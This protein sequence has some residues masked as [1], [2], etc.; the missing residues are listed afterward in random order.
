M[1]LSDTSIDRP[2]LT[3]VVTASILLA[4]WLG[5]QNL[6]VRELPDVEYPI[7]NVQTVL[8]G[9][10]PEVMETEVTEVLEEE[11]NTIEGIKTLSSV[12]SEQTSTITAEFELSRDVD[13]A[14]QDVRARVSRVSQQ[15]PDDVEDP[16]IQ[17][18]DP[19][20]QP[21]MW[22]TVRNPNAS[23]TEMNDIAENV[24]QERLQTIEG[25]G[26]IQVGG[27]RRF[28]VRIDLDPQQMG[29]YGLT[30]ADVSAALQSGNV[31]VPSGRIESES[32]EFTVRTEGE[33]ETPE[34]FNE[35][36]VGYRRGTPIRLSDVG[37][38]YGG[39]EN[40]RSLAR[41]NGDPTVG[42]GVVKQSGANTVALA[43]RALEAVDELRGEVPAGYDLTVAVNSAE[44]IEQSLH[45]VEETLFIAF[46]LVVLV[47][48]LFLQSGRAT[49]IPSLAIPVSIVGTFAALY[50]L[51][52]SVNTL[53]LL[54]LVLAI[55]IVVDD[56]IVVVENIHRHLEEGE[57]PIEAARKGTSEIAFAVIAISLTLVIVFLPIGLMQGI[58]GRLFR[59]FGI[60]V[61]VSVLI[62]AFVAL[63][64]S[65]MLSSRFL[66]EEDEEGK[67]RV[68]RA[69]EAVLQEGTDWYRA[70]LEWSLD[71]RWL[72]VGL[73]VVSLAATAFVA[74][75]MGQE[76]VPR[77]DRGQIIVQMQAPVGS[78]LEYTDSYLQQ[79]EGILGE[80]EGV[81]RYFSAAGF[82]GDVTSGFAYVRLE[83]E[84]ERGQFEIMDEIRGRVGQLAGVDVFLI[85]P[86]SLQQGAGQPVQF[87]VQ[88][89]DLDSLSHYAD[90]LA[91]RT[92]AL[93]GF[94]GVDTNVDLNKPELTV[95]V[96]RDKA[97]SLGIDVADVGTTLQ[98]LMGGVDLS[99]FE[100]GGERYEV[101]VQAGD[102]ARVTPQDLS[103]LYLRGGEGQLV[104]LA[105]VVNVE[106]GVSPNQINHYNRRRSITVSSG[107]T[108]GLALGTA[109]E[110]VQQAADEVLPEEFT[111]A[112]SGQSQ[113]FRESFQSLLFALAMA[114]VAVY[115]VLA[116][117]F[118]SFVHPFTIMLALPLALVGAVAGLAALGMTLNIY[119]M[120][121]II[122]LMGLVTKNS[123][124]LVDFANQ[125][126]RGGMERDRAVVRAG[127]VRLR[128]ILMTSVA[129]IIGVTPIALALGAGA[130]SRR[131]LG[132]AVIAGMITSTA[133]TLIVVPVFY[134]M[135]DDGVRWVKRRAAAL[136]G[137]GSGGDAGEGATLPG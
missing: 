19:D 128:P 132:V 4:G 114:V 32:R 64:L 37:R 27:Q 134:L 73:G 74:S 5:Y 57:G 13:F 38:A 133:L 22:I 104:Q 56:A 47:V 76:F 91:A 78:T 92:R 15:L 24:L 14:L 108:G 113:D 63:T 98:V 53:T 23:R 100:Q 126:R 1:F 87:V 10:S 60:A 40:D 31:E 11:I 18:V 43:D 112:V 88:G 75:R 33:F 69:M 58:V 93:P 6:P 36:I 119:S 80:T 9:A 122:M 12:S 101:M 110:Q 54:A 117:Q 102:S 121:G 35:L 41:F 51:G 97:A 42:V 94:Q 125:A 49:L 68:F 65:P 26:R 7:V 45:E 30:V 116:G 123:I 118:E 50:A 90:S 59:Q 127:V 129:I 25:V 120:I 3:T 55:G 84:R 28:A 131:P 83:E 136:T 46:G 79:V 20:A 115:L 103:S 82:G 85:A 8:P 67:N 52:F 124:L 137:A 106:E 130:E 89:P 109:L 95:S 77:E 66:R 17:K 44:F 21:I 86:S 99:D 72:I 61:A 135:L 96:D 105:G 62:S 107:L 48:L 2:V 39:A 70:A 71:R 34:A 16:V 111:T 81:D 29:A